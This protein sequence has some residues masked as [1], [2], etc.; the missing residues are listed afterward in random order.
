MYAFPLAF[1]EWIYIKHALVNKNGLTRYTP[2]QLKNLLCAAQN[3][4]AQAINAL[5]QVFEPLIVKEAHRRY[6]TAILGEDAVNIAWQ[7]FLEFIHGYKGNNYRL[8][9]GLLQ[10]RLHYGL[11]HAVFPEKETI[12]AES[13]DDTDESGVQLPSVDTLLDLR[14]ERLDLT[15]ALRQLTPTQQAVV[16]DIFF[17]GLTLREC[18]AK[19]DLTPQTCHVYKNRALRKLHK[20]LNE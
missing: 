6:I 12:Q 2:T 16:T 14:L 13:L 19:R 8:L 17:L 3:Y 7:I 5:C 18:S 1:K 15:Q 4:D 9:P 10:K 20:I 11:L